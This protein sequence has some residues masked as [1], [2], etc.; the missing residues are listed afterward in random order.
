MPIEKKKFAQRVKAFCS[1]L[2]VRERWL[3]QMS[4][5][6]TWLKNY[7]LEQQRIKEILDICI[8]VY[9]EETIQW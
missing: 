9:V 5:A 6:S 1:V 2:W 7:S 8:Y 3:F 4:L